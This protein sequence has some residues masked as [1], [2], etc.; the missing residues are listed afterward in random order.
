MMV[1][2]G[3][4][5]GRLIREGEMPGETKGV[6][7]DGSRPLVRATWEA[8]G[9]GRRR[10]AGDGVGNRACWM[11][12]RVDLRRGGMRVCMRQIGCGEQC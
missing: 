6:E 8:T 2:E 4:S 5:R 11:G 9:S 12:G 7:G 3:D 10:E 1:D